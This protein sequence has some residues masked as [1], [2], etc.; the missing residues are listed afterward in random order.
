MKRTIN[1]LFKVIKAKKSCE[2]CLVDKTGF[3]WFIG[4]NNNYFTGARGYW[5]LMQKNNTWSIV[6]ALIIPDDWYYDDVK[7]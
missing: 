3:V 6:N 1:N 7:Y 5:L 2:S 4:S